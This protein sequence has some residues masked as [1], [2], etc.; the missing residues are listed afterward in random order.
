MAEAPDSSILP[1][2]P[3]FTAVDTPFDTMYHTGYHRGTGR[4]S[5]KA[6]TSSAR[7]GQGLGTAHRIGFIIK[8]N[9][10]VYSFG[11]FAPCY[12]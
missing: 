10:H 3:G 8:F 5:L 6:D 9:T 2:Y 1:E 11:A 4:G 7:M 12:V